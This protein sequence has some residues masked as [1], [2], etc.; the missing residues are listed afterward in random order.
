MNMTIDTHNGIWGGNSDLNN[1]NDAE[2]LIKDMFV[3]YAKMIYKYIRA[4]IGSNEI[5]EELMNDT[6]LVAF[7]KCE[8]FKIVSNKKAWLYAVAKILIKN[9]YSHVKN[10]EIPTVPIDESLEDIAIETEFLKDNFDVFKTFLTEDEI[11]FIVYKYMIGYKNIEIS[12]I[13][14]ISYTNCSTKLNRIRKKIEKNYFGLWQ[15]KWNMT[16]NM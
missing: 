11:D 10:R 7:N 14:G 4:S 16:L 3:T 8:D 15:F 2:D 5:S 9:Y 6:F 12:R 13:M 1:R